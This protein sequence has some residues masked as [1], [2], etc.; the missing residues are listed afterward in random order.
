MAVERLEE[1]GPAPRE[2][3]DSKRVNII[4]H[5]QGRAYITPAILVGVITA[6]YVAIGSFI[7]H[8]T[9]SVK[10]VLGPMPTAA[11]RGR[12]PYRSS[13]GPP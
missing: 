10:E 9:S 7:L 1:V 13:R 2:A 5:R 4:N 11:A 6:F 8:K 12:R 3:R